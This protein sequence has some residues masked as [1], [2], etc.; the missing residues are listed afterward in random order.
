MTFREDK[1]TRNMV[2]FVSTKI[3][4]RENYSLKGE[5]TITEKYWPNMLHEKNI[6]S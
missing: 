3:I 1:L 4:F 6:P 5:K 2:K